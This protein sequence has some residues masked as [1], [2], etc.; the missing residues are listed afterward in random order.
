MITLTEQ[1]EPTEPAKKRMLEQM[2]DALEDEVASLFRR[3]ATFEEELLL[4]RG[5]GE[6]QT[7]I[8]RLLLKLEGVRAERDRV[9][10]K[11]GA[12]S[13]EAEAMR[14]ELFNDGFPESDAAEST[15]SRIPGE[16]FFRRITSGDEL[17]RF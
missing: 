10:E 2:A 1:D 7:E 11:I 17:H 14:E 6:R 15:S 4:N 12:I 5:I 3:A 13:R 8:N 16:P 9:M